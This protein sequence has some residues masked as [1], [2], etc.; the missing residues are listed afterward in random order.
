[1]YHLLSVNT[2]GMR[3]NEFI[4]TLTH[5]KISQITAHE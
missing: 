4:N 3:E 5:M 2:K 1:M